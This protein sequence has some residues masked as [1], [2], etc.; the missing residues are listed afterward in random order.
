MRT[1]LQKIFDE[2]APTYELVNRVLTLGLDGRWR[3]K[4]ARAAAA[5]RAS[6][7]S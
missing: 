4:A 2:V 5:R 1:G 6:L 7:K 3:K